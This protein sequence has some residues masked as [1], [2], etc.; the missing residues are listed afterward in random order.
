M[1][2]TITV[3]GLI[4]ANVGVKN[5][6]Q[7][8]FLE[9][10]FSLLPAIRGRFNFCNLARY[11]KFNE[12]TFR[13][14]FSKAFDWAAFNYALIQLNV[15]SPSS[16]LIAA[17]D[18]SFISKAGKKTFG[19]GKFWSGCA[20]KAKKGLEVTAL[21]LIEVSSGT[22]WTLDVCQTPAGL[23]AKAG[24]SGKYTRI[25][26]YIEQLLDCSKYLNGVLY[27]VADGYYA[28]KKMFSAVLSMGKHLITKL[29]PDANMKYL[30]D[31]TKNPD[32]YKGAVLYGATS[33]LAFIR[34]LF[35][36]TI[37]A[38]TIL[39]IDQDFQ[40]ELKDKLASLHPYQISKKGGHLQEWYYDWE[41]VDP[42]HR[43]QT[44]LYG[45]HP[46]HHISVD[47][48]PE[49]AKACRVTLNVKGDKSTGWSQGWRVNLWARLKDGNRAHQLYRQLLNYV[50]PS[51]KI[52]YFA[53]GGTYPNLLDAH[54]PFQIDGNFS[55]AAGVIE[56]LVQSSEETITLLPALPD[57]WSSGSISGVKARGGYELSFQ[58]TDKKVSS[59]TIF[60]E[61]GG[62]TTIVANGKKMEVLLE[63]GEKSARVLF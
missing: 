58:W 55:G 59:L 51:D 22:A 14:N 43:H 17:V 9:E 40:Q 57:E 18:A 29:R 2:S 44:H 26:Y 61:N 20:G 12:V 3:L 27:I 56:M 50:Q 7:R 53:K 1:L 24:K 15:S 49:L 63:K 21:A 62:K 52:N 60:S 38:A 32:G 28:K 13:R 33:D 23:S 47:K 42:K 45:L 4:F 16:A 30:F 41:D 11:S 48:T 35:D 54:P 39:N 37:K 36:V 46:G 8:T 34:E 19:F 31:R 5:K 25:D 10:L 6:S